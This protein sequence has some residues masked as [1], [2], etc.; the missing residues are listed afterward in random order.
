MLV[1]AGAAMFYPGL[2]GLKAR[3][4]REL[5]ELK[6][7]DAERMAR[8]VMKAIRRFSELNNRE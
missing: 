6:G 1:A 4:M 8:S 3:A 2:V 5:S 7:E